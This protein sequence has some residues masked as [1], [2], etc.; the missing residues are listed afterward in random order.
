MVLKKIK[1]ILSPKK[2]DSKEEFVEFEE[3]AFAMERKVNVRIENLKG[4]SDVDRIQQMVREGDV[5]FLRIKELRSKDITELKRVVERLKKTCAA[6][7]GDIVGV[8][9]DFLI[10]TPS[11]AKVF[12]GKAG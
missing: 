6:M 5:V 2:E 7:N 12:R 4:F 1:K 11:F 9:E 10:V 3:S 8:D